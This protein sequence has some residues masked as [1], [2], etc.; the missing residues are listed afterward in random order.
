VSLGLAISH[1][2]LCVT[3]S[4]KTFNRP[5]IKLSHFPSYLVEILESH[6]G[7]AIEGRRNAKWQDENR[8]LNET[9]E[10]YEKLFEIH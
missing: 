9:S 6:R 3:C 10:G 8:G 1:G 4:T 7:C 2:E 5:I